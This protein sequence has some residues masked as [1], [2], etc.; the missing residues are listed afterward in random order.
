MTP[1]EAFTAA[2]ANVA[3]HGDTDIF[4]FPFEGHLFRDRPDE[5]VA[6]LRQLHASFDEYLASYPPQAIVTLNQVGYTGF[7]WATQIDPFWNAYYLA[8]VLR[9]ASQ[10]EGT[11]IPQTDN[12]VFSY[13]FEWQ[14]AEGKLFKDSTWSDYKRCSIDLARD[15]KFVIVTDISDF[16]PRVYHHRVQNALNSLPRP[17]DASGRVMTLLKAFSR[18]DVSYGLPIGGP[19]SRILAELA[20]A[21]VDRHLQARRIRFCRYADDYTIF[22]GDRAEAYRTL[23]FLSEQLFNEGLV[24]QKTKTRVLTSAEFL[25]SA[26]P[27]LPPGPGEVASEERKLLSIHVRYDP[28]SP[29]AVED[30]DALKAALGEV[31]IVGILGREVAKAAIDPTVSRQAIAAIRALAPEMQGNA[32]RTVMHPDNLDVLTPVFVS[33]LRLV[34]SVYTDLVERDKDFVDE[35]LIGLHANRSPLFSLDLN[36][37][38][39]IQ[40]LGQ[41]QSREKE[42]LLVQLFESAQTPLVRRMIILALA[43][44]R[45]R[46]WLTDVR[47][48]YG[49]LTSWEKRAFIIASY[50]LGDEGDHW[51]RGTRRTWSPMDNLTRDWFAERYQRTGEIPL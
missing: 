33:I 19:A 17:G 6:V 9:V 16:Y 37:A 4:P 1:D 21:G 43:R 28:Y 10:I 44:W 36:I 27:Y 5:A 30:Y 15:H 35:T 25:E 20:L 41:R 22:C 12:A 46:Y 39:S 34:R 7:R 18:L 42:E 45:C 8:S 23:V 24:L 2:V 51:R 14:A 26:K 49:G 32:I 31:D 13:R 29:T 50:A 11:R 47:G 48:R 3:S 38:Y 40:V